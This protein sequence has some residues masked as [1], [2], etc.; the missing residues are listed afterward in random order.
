LIEK[1]NN[2]FQ[3]MPQF[4]YQQFCAS[5]FSNVEY[6]NAGEDWGIEGLRRA[7][8]SYHPCMLAK[9]FLVYEK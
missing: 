4:I 3:G 7:K 9:K 8:M 6:V 1:T 5:D 2:R